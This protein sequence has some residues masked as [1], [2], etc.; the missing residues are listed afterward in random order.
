M[1]QVQIK[2]TLNE[3]IAAD[4]R[5]LA[6]QSACSIQRFAQE[7][8]EAEVAAHRLKWAVPGVDPPIRTLEDLEKGT[9]LTEL[10]EEHACI[11]DGTTEVADRTGDH[12]SE[13]GEED[14]GGRSAA[15]P[16]PSEDFGE[17]HANEDGSS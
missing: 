7:L 10:P 12:G 8:V 3:V 2:I 1:G 15:G 16:E 14:D 5:F 11:D 6:A 13:A 4:L 17:N 9:G